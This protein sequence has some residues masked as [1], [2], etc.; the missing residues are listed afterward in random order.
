MARLT[1]M[2]P[3]T[4]ATPF[5]MVIRPLL[6]NILLCSSSLFGVCSL[7]SFFISPFYFKRKPIESPMLE[8]V[9]L[10]LLTIESSK[11][12]PALKLYCF[13]R[14]RNSLSSS[15]QTILKIRIY[16]QKFGLYCDF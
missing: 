1:A 2:L 13:A 8:M 12:D 3:S 16:D 6:C 4:L 7:V 9:N 5:F 11:V 14:F 10:S 15:W